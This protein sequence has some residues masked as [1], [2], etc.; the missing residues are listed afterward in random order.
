M[1]LVLS[2]MRAALSV[3]MGKMLKKSMKSTD[4]CTIR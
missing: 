1:A 4:H 2:T 3:V